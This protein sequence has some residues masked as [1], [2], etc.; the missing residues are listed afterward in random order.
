MPSEGSHMDATVRLEHSVLAVEEEHELHAMV[1]L[2]VP[3]LPEDTTRPPLR[4]ALVVDRSGS[5]NGR[6]LAAAKR[7]AQWLAER[8]RLTDELALVAFDDQVRLLTPL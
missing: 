4:V 8:L 3:A 7:C 6:K 5:M 1:E 2:A